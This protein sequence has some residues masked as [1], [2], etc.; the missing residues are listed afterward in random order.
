MGEGLFYHIHNTHAHTHTHTHTHTHAHMHTHTHTHS[1]TDT[2]F[3]FVPFL[4]ISNVFFQS[5]M[6]RDVIIRILCYFCQDYPRKFCYFL[7]VSILYKISLLDIVFRP[8]C[9]LPHFTSTIKRYFRTKK[10]PKIQ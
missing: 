1:H 9:S 7:A 2:F 8:R 3:R 6:V 5:F 10:V 4:P